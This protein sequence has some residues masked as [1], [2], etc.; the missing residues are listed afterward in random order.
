MDVLELGLGFQIPTDLNMGD[1]Q[2]ANDNYIEGTTAN[3]RRV[4]YHDW[5]TKKNGYVFACLTLRYIN[6]S[7]LMLYKILQ[8][9]LW[10]SILDPI[11]L[12][13]MPDFSG[14]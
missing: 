6:P 10:G 2:I 13:S 8:L 14:F 7:K 12:I 4:S 9:I 11:G 1:S 5:A 3:T